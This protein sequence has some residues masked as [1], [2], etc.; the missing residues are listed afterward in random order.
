MAS[1]P[2]H[3][4]GTPNCG[5][6]QEYA[7]TVRRHMRVPSI[8]L[9]LVV[10]GGAAFAAGCGP[11]KGAGQWRSM[12]AT[13]WKFPSFA[14]GHLNGELHDRFKPTGV[15]GPDFRPKAWLRQ[16]GDQE[17]FDPRTVVGLQ[18]DRMTKYRERP[19]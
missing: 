6:S 2:R 18:E 13:W 12:E 16:S 11:A 17:R 10:L 15:I 8:V 9:A 7:L 1:P 14:P 19:G 4:A 5:S 3:C